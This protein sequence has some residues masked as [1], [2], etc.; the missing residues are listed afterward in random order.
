MKKRQVA[1]QEYSFNTL[2]G[3][4]DATRNALF[5]VAEQLSIQYRSNVLNCSLNRHGDVVLKTTSFVGVI[6]IDETLSIEI[7]PKIYN[8]GE[9]A[10]AANLRNLFYML[11]YSG[12]F[13]FPNKRL[14]SLEAYNGSFFETLIG[15]FAE[16]LLDKIQ[17]SAHHEYI[18][19]QSNRAYLKGKL[20]L[21][22]HLKINVLS[23][24]RF[25]TQTDDFTA[26]NTL[27]QTLKY[28]SKGLYKLTRDA[29]NKKRL[30]KCLALF[31]EVDDVRVSHQMASRIHLTRL[32]KRFEN[33]LMLSKLFLKNQTLVAKSGKHS[34]WTILIDM[35]VLFEE[36]IAR[37]LQEGLRTST[38]K[39]VMQGP[40]K[41]FV[42][43]IEDDR[44]VFTMK[45]DI[46][47][48]R[49]SEVVRIAD[50]KYKV[51]NEDDRKYGVAQ[52]DLYQMFAY[53]RRYAVSDITLI[54]P[55][56]NGVE[57]HTLELPDDTKVHIRTISLSRDLRKNIKE[58][59]QEVVA[60]FT[61]R[62]AE[63]VS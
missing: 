45:P 29:S 34:S 55:K 35:N 12:Q 44:G 47:I 18:S 27:N 16:E 30:R 38:Y 5:D 7:T 52:S 11:S 51:L 8:S 50:T 56:T 13:T 53:S 33:L 61:S 1:I 22:E 41:K 10:T 4:S 58:I 49:G 46:S 36:F 9:D 26:N 37:A 28:V 15:M 48:V 25:Y 17:N 54:Y 31:D 42:R 24:N 62:V 32:N 21:T 40:Q 63:V 14:S 59:E 43:N 39:V 60:M 19:E 2:A 3:L 6:D 23:A 20:L 57:S